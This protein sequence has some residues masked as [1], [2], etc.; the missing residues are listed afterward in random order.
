MD[1]LGWKEREEWGGGEEGEEVVDSSGVFGMIG[2]DSAESAEGAH[3]LAR[4]RVGGK[5]WMV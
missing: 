4:G 1:G 2:V 3:L 5:G